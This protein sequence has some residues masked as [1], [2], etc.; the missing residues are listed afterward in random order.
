MFP[1]VSLIPPETPVP[2]SMPITI[3][4]K[5]DGQLVSLDLLS[6]PGTGTNGWIVGVSLHHL[7]S[8]PHHLA[9]SLKEISDQPTTIQDQLNSLA[10]VV[11][12]NQRR[13]DLHSPAHGGICPTLHEQCCFY[14]NR[15]KLV[16]TGPK[17]LGTR[18]RELSNKPPPPWVGSPFSHIVAPPATHSF[19]PCHPHT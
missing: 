7:T 3:R 13:L 6:R 10:P 4:A 1:T 8:L 2:V 16:E 17:D 19:A 12:Q 5:Q 11:T 18:H 15:S 14:T 9:E